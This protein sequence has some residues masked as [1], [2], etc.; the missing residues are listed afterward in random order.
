MSAVLKEK[1]V[2]NFVVRLCFK[3]ETWDG[4]DFCHEA[5][6]RKIVHALEQNGKAEFVVKEVDEIVRFELLPI[7]I[8]HMILNSSLP[9][10]DWAWCSRC[11]AKPR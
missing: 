4:K 1:A 8:C 5:F 7:R 9:P 10:K 11:M 6:G 3:D 2:R